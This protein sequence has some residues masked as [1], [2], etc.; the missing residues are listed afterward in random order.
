MGVQ[1]KIL[2][3]FLKINW[4]LV[5]KAKQLCLVVSGLSGFI[6]PTYFAWIVYQENIPQNIASWSMVFALDVLGLTLVMKAG[7]KEPYLQTGWV[8]AAFLVLLSVLFNQ[9]PWHWG[10]TES[11][12]LF[13]CAVAVLLWLTKTARVALWAYIAA[14]WISFVPLMVD[15]WHVPQVDTLWLWLATIAS[16]LFS[17]LGS[18]K[19]DF[20]N[21][22]VPWAV[23]ALNSVISTLCIL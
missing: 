5:V 22:G 17:I 13:L 7:N 6:I 20:T 12:S 16:C 11:T 18:E 8:V 23:I 2:V 14:M 19:R 9:S 4:R 3:L 1:N 10:W 21:T 15:Y